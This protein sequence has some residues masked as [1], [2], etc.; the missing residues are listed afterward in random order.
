[1]A[2]D[3]GHIE[4]DFVRKLLREIFRSKADIIVPRSGDRKYEPLFAVYRKSALEAINKVL[5]SGGRRISDVFALCKVK[6]IE[7]GDR[8]RLIN[9][10]TMAEYEEFQKKCSGQV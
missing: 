3:I 4:M 5:C 2:C 10:N 6:Y 9:L 7:I 8:E 1:M